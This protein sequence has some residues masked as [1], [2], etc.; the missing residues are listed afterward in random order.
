[1][2]PTLFLSQDLHV[3]NGLGLK[4]PPSWGDGAMAQRFNCKAC[5][6]F[7]CVAQGNDQ[8]TRQ[9]FC[10]LIYKLCI[11]SDSSL[12]YALLLNFSDLVQSKLQLV[13]ADTNSVQLTLHCR[14]QH[15]LHWCLLATHPPLILLHLSWEIVKKVPHGPSNDTICTYL[16][17]HNNVTTTPSLQIKCLCMQEGTP[18]ERN[19][20]NT[21]AMHLH[22]F[23]RFEC[24]KMMLLHILKGLI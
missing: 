2:P 1:M 24:C 23:A 17:I 5:Q 7:R 21:G 16:T 4:Q 22:H 19:N 9:E 15:G 14:F 11:G 6:Y 13:Q 3:C 18:T 8:Q 12:C 10:S 20:D